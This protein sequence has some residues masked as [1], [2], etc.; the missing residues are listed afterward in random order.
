MT[1]LTTANLKAVALSFI[2]AL[3]AY[4]IYWEATSGAARRALARQDGCLPAKP[5][6]SK[7]LLFGLDVF[8]NVKAY[9][10]HRLL[11]RWT[12]PLT[13]NNAHTLIANI[14]GQNIF[15]TDDSKNVKTMLA[16]NFDQWSL[17][18]ERIQ[19]ME[20][21]LGYGIFTSEGA[22]WK[23]SRDMLRACFERSQVADI[24]ILE[25]HTGRLLQN[26]LLHELTL[27][28]ATEFLFGR[29]TDAQDYNREDN[30][31]KEFI[32]AFEY[33]QN[34]MGE[35]SEKYGFLAAF[36]PDGKFK[37]R[38]KTIRDEL[39]SATQNRTVI[40]SELL[41]ILLAGRDTTASL[42]S[43]LIWELSRQPA[44]LSRLRR[45]IEDAILPRGGRLDS[46]SP[47]LV[48]EGA[49]VAYLPCAIYRPRDV[50]G[51]DAHRFDPTRWLD[52]G[53]ASS[54]LR[55][56]WA[57]LPFS[58]GPRICIGQNFALTECI[59]VVVRLLQVFYVERRDEEPWREKLGI[60][61]VGLG[62]CKVG[63]TPRG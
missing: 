19:Q 45:E 11:E 6:R 35:R 61:C 12:K 18:Q 5:Y 4:R 37:K 1:L 16:T 17:G 44:M 34:P 47:T 40:R 59:F 14:F 52:E 21:Y 39:L 60:T 63:L 55:P 62:G 43:N 36:L 57:Y 56:G 46:Q 28:I 30:A 33:C 10:E 9:R 27:D 50:Y 24:S 58:G 23:H 38:A 32:E 51:D 22:S 26:P 3:I 53:H 20:A 7:P 49:Y 54:P 8:A 42:L 29:S 31:C 25:K 2:G 13:S 41:N 15:W 48:P